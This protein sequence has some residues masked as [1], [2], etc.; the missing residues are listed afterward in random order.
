MKYFRLFHITL[1]VFVRPHVNI[2]YRDDELIAVNKPSGL[3]V[4]PTSEATDRN[5]CLSIVR[6][7]IGQFVYPLHR[8]DRGTSGL[9]LMGL[10]A[11]T[12]RIMNKAFAERNIEKTYL[13]IVR[14][15]VDGHGVLDRPLRKKGEQ[16]ESAL[17]YYR[18]L[19][20]CQLPYPVGR[21]PV[22]R[23][24]LVEAKPVTGRRHQIRRHLSNADHPIVGDTVH[25]DGKHNRL[26]R[27]L[28]DC[29]HVLLHAASIEFDHPS[30]QKRLRLRVPPPEDFSMICSRMGLETAS[31]FPREQDGETLS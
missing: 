22:A 4:H 11:D 31:L 21:Y 6:D 16:K 25:G 9:L 24:S 23:Y 2:V 15:W 28:F 14:G 5:T 29:Y 10:D 12:A 30:E 18:N 19:A 17:T 20:H 3:L 27:Q 1:C 26:F 8:L 13:A 7:Q